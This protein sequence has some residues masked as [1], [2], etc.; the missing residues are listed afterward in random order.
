MS[1]VDATWLEEV[2]V[3]LL[4]TPTQVPLGETEIQ[5]G[6]PRIAEAVEKV[7]LPRIEELG[8][9]EIR[10]H[11][12]GD[13]AAR[14]GPLG[15]DGVLLQTYIV[16]QH[17]NLMEDPHAGRIVDG[18]PYGFEGPCA[19]GQGATQNKGPMSSAL[20][21]VRALPQEELHRPI[22]LTVNTEGKSSHDGSRRI[23]EE[24]GVS[25]AF[26][27]VAIGTDLRVS[28]GN[29]GR[30]DVE[31][32]IAGSSCHSS[33]PWLGSNPIEGAADVIRALRSTPLPEAHPELGPASATPYQLACS[34][35]APHT[36]PS[37]VRMMV[38]R[39]L[40]P[41]EAPRG[42]ADAIRVY[43]ED[44][45]K[46]VELDVVPGEFMLPAVVDPASPVVRAL[47]DGIEETTE[48]FG[49]TFWS[50]NT[51][52]A[53][54]PCSRGIHTVMFGA[55]KRSFSGNGLIGTDAVSIADCN[56]A[57]EAMA[58]ALRRLGG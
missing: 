13:V 21:A 26:G 51:F 2:L 18:R 50:P 55:G 37:E 27:I 48:R 3:E 34:P 56:I 8:P 17:A 15:D 58:Y 44:S 12:Q 45:L 9:S 20:A 46:D 36:I 53:G 28:L 52:D 32:R 39:R 19:L 24:L 41:G 29:R 33:Q 43:L 11:P 16:S 42:A 4:R 25:T 38:D 7:V 22:W 30:I 47:L 10:R 40:L 57:A 54:Y 5:P 31:V 35:L 23:I 49:Q 1:A 14:F 6:D